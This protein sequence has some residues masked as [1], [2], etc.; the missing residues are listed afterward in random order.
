VCV[1]GGGGG[2][3]CLNPAYQEV[4]LPPG[5]TPPVGHHDQ[6]E[7]LP[8]ELLHGMRRLQCRVGEPDLARLGDDALRG[9]GGTR[10]GGDVE[11]HGVG[12]DADD[13][14]RDTPQPGTPG[15]DRLGPAAAGLPPGVAVE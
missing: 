5:E 10:V 6:R 4:T 1:C 3:L 8:V 13:P 12:L 15:D 11:H 2:G 9:V 7:G 14:H